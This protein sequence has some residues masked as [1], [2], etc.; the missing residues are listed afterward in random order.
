MS[1]SSTSHPQRPP[2]REPFDRTGTVGSQYGAGWSSPV[3]RRAHNPKVGGSNPPPATT[4]SHPHRSA[5]LVVQEDAA[6]ARLTERPEGE[7]AVISQGAEDEA[8]GHDPRQSRREVRYRSPATLR[9]IQAHRSAEH[10]HLCACRGS[11]VPETG[12]GG[13]LGV[14]FLDSKRSWP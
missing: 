5:S 14:E 11:S 1:S 6:V 8:S 12:T 2:D 10:P 4:T 9:A 3:A 13:R 7:G